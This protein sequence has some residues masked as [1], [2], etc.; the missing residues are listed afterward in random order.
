MT[1]EL[2]SL[3]FVGVTIL[4]VFAIISAASAYNQK[5]L[6]SWEGRDARD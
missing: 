2:T 4:A 3:S 5:I 1:A 6:S